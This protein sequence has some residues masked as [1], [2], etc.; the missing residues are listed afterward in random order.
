MENPRFCNCCITRTIHVQIKTR[1]KLTV[2]SWFII[3]FFN[4]LCI[5]V[6]EL[7]NFVNF[8]VSCIRVSM[9]NIYLSIFRVLKIFPKISIFIVYR[10]IKLNTISLCIS[11][12][13]EFFYKISIF[14]V[15]STWLYDVHSKFIVIK[16]V[17]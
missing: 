5:T 14:I 17:S 7:Y 10:I 13:S 12:I 6:P 1:S 11:C 3:P 8:R 4:I 2:S 16:W 9:I 15:Y